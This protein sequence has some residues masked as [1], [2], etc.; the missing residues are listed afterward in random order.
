MF[1]LFFICLFSLILFSCSNSQNDKPVAKSVKKEK[2]LDRNKVAQSVYNA[3]AKFYFTDKRGETKLESP[4]FH[5]G[6]TVYVQLK[7]YIPAIHL[8]NF[9]LGVCAN[10]ANPNIKCTRVDN[11]LYSIT[12]PNS[13][14]TQSFTFEIFLHHNDILFKNAYFDTVD[15]VDKNEI[16]HT[17]G[18]CTYGFP[19]QN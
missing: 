17:I 12:L 14:S 8:K 15:G 13:N 19:V 18:I 10:Y 9:R 4:V 11:N 2:L 5:A 7:E 1:K 3:K 6:D 16:G